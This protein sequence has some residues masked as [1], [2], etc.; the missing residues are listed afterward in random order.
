ML[1]YFVRGR[2]LVRD[3]S[4]ELFLRSHKTGVSAVEG[5]VVC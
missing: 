4:G 3:V 2:C 1:Q 5:E